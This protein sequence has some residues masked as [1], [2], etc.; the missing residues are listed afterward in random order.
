VE[1][2]G[3]AGGTFQINPL[4]A[5]RQDEGQLHLTL[6]FPDRDYEE[7]FGACRLYLP[8]EATVDAAALRAL[9]AGGSID[10]PLADLV[11]RRV[12]VDLPHRYY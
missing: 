8:E 7:E 9:Q 5:V 3:H 12:I 10:G 6:T 1:P 11:R 4:Y 2:A